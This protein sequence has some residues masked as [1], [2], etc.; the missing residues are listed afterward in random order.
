MKR[1]WWS[2]TAAAVGFG[3]VSIS[4]S[5]IV[6]GQKSEPA[7]TPT[8]NKDVAPILYNHCASCHRP[9]Q[10]APFSLLT[11]ADAAKRSSLI[12][13]LTESRFMP[14]WKPVPGHGDFKD[15]N[16]LS[17]AEL[18]TLKRW[19]EA[20]APEG[21]PADLP[22]LPHF[23][24][25]WQLGQPDLVLKMPQA[26]QIPAEGEDV[27]QCFVMPLNLPPGTSV[28][29]VEIHPGNRKVLHHSILYLND[30]GTAQARDKATTEPGYR[31]FGGPGVRSA[32]SLGGWVPGAKPHRLPAGVAMTVPQG[33]ELVMQNHYH[34]SGKPE[35]DQS[36]L[37]IYFA[38][39]PVEKTVFSVPMMQRN[40]NIPAGDSNYR[41]SATF[42]T[43][44]DLEVIGIA[45]H[46]HLLGQDMKV[47][48][49][50]PDGQVK[51]MIWIK[52]WDFNWQGMYQ[53]QAPLSLPKGTR[54]ELQAV[55]DNSPANPKNPN[56]PPQPVHW[57]ENTT[58]EMCLAFIQV[59]TSTPAD[60][61]TVL[62]SLA[63]QLDLM[64]Y[65]RQAN[66][67]VPTPNE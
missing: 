18:A 49:T 22:A 46:M 2:T 25:G 19:A 26:F 57:G 17:D 58:D 39:G 4:C 59:Q 61:L 50:L 30:D 38:K 32:G 23:P 3:L 42:V 33:S 21:D 11:Y 44:I 55:Y 54:I 37:G 14:P 34:P 41:V 7:P 40:L 31:C 66:L 52:D 6:R 51:S 64:R 12:A 1:S 35:T 45:P 15:A 67:R 13:D 60:R 48:A 24:D 5:N 43:P 47:I 9:G 53:Y 16:Y 20:K 27:Y 28:A 8:F 63:K 65:R 56:S 62:L 10:V 29:A 36:E